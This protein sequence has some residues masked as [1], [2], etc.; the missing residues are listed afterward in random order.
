MEQSKIIDTLETYQHVGMKEKRADAVIKSAKHA[1]SA[2][3]LLRSVRASETKNRAVCGDKVA[4]CKIIELLPVV[5]LQHM[6]GATKLRG[7]IG[8][9]CGESGNRIRLSP[10]REGP[11]IVRKIIKDNKII[12]IA[13]ACNRRGPNITMN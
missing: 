7:D 5:C 9:E 11:H 8:V 6:N 1:L 2:A 10:Q 4:D 12:E 13:R 3:I